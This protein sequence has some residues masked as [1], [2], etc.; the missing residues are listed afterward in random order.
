MSQ[1]LLTLGQLTSVHGIQGWLKVFSYTDPMTGILNYPE[2]ILEQDSQQRTV[3]L[4]QGRQ[5]GKALVV[6]LEGI[7]DRTAA[8]ALKGAWI[9][10]PKAALPALPQG[11]FYWWQLEGLRVQTQAGVELGVVSHLLSTGG[12]NDVLVVRATQPDDPQ[13]ERLLPWLMDRV[14]I[15]VDLDSG[16]IVVDWDPEF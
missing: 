6:R 5:Q 10:V 15:D 12:A 16:Q 14:I 11:D 8:E 3:K 9:K 4:A 7:I 13:S 1:E 2:W